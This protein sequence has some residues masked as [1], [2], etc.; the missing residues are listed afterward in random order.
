MIFALPSL[1][2]IMSFLTTELYILRGWINH[3]NKWWHFPLSVKNED[4]QVG[5]EENNLV[6][7]VYKQKTQSDLEMF[8]HT[9]CFRP[10][11]PTLIKTAKNG[12]MATRPDLMVNIISKHLPKLE[13]INFGNMDQR[14]KISGL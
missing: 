7:N 14:Q 5:E 6:N 13:A 2:L 1:E 9:T 8:L 12:N 11:K 10:V 4:K 3:Q